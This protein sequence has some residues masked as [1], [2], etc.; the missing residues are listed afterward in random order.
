M[1]LV[2]I[3]HAQTEH[4]QP[5]HD[6]RRAGTVPIGRVLVVLAD[7]EGHRAL[8]LWLRGPAALSLCWLASRPSGEPSGHPSDAPSDQPS[9]ARSGQP[10]SAS[11]SLP[12]E[13]PPGKLTVPGLPGLDLA[14]RLLRA[15]GGTVTGVDIGELGP[16]VLAA[17]IQVTS[18]AGSQ[19]VTTHPASA[20]TLAAVTDAPVRV[21][22]A[23]MDRLAAPVT[24]DDLPGQFR[25]Q[26]PARSA[27]PLPGPRNLGFADGLDGWI[28]SG[29]SRAEATGSHR[30]DYAVSAAGGVATLSA[31][32]P[33]PYGN[34]FPGQVI[35]AGDYRGTSVS[36]RGEVRAENVAD[37]AEPFLFI[38]TPDHRPGP[39]VDVLGPAIAGRHDWTRYEI[40]AQVPGDGE[41]IRFGLT[42]TGPGQ[43]ALRNAELTHPSDPQPST[44]PRET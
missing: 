8:P 20:L 15:A 21:A 3:A 5:E 36:F 39:D 6:Q 9:G 32:V 1:T 38:V 23:L 13:L 7:D 17:Q 37:Q 2:R 10:P 31:A 44:P 16:G 25:D 33:H 19:Q 42:L 43:V 26:R 27:G 12:G 29:S 11:A 40:T 30:D 41:L 18:S 22:D 34:V 24:G 28:T 4:D 35:D 14:D